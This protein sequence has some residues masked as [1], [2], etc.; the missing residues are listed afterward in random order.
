MTTSNQPDYR[1]ANLE[2]FANPEGGPVIFQPRIDFWISEN[3]RL[4]TLPEEFADLDLYGVHD[5]LGCS[6]RPYKIFNNCI[7]HYD[8]Q[9]GA[10]KRVYDVPLEESIVEGSIESRNYVHREVMTTPYGDL[11]TLTRHKEN[12]N[13]IEQY[14]V[15]GPEHFRALEYVLEAQAFTF[16]NEFFARENER[17]G[18]RGEPQLFMQR[19]NVMQMMVHWTGMEGFMLGLIGE[20]TK[21]RHLLDVIDRREMELVRLLAASPIRIINYGDNIDCH[22]CPPNYLMEFVKPQYERRHEVFHPADKFVHSH[23]DGSL[24]SLLP[25]LKEIPLDGFEA[26]TPLP[27]GDVSI[28]E[29]R[30]A[31]P[32]GIVVMDMIP[33]THFLSHNPVEELDAAV[34]KIV[35]LFAPRLILGVSDEVSPVCDIER[36]RRVAKYVR[37]L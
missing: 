30:E 18:N 31:V 37:E 20:P 12:A 3:R 11:E 6:V 24:K 23:F 8:S 34:E 21:M 16:N 13:H 7:T 33:M 1:H 14:P 22:M 10:R 26:L 28:E 35:E 9:T 25:C 27:Q 17:L 36:V 15:R 29:L 5:A 4:G 32:E 19:V 2:I